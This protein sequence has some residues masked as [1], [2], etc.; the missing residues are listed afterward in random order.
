M[1][2]AKALTAK[3][4]DHIDRLAAFYVKSEKNAELLDVMV[5]LLYISDVNGASAVLVKRLKELR[6][7]AKRDAA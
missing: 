5:S 1:A 2:R 4:L 7:E 6:A 3:H